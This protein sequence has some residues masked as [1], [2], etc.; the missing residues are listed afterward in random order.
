MFS[1]SKKLKGFKGDTF[2]IHDYSSKEDEKNMG[3]NL[4][5]FEIVQ[6]LSTKN[7]TDYTCKV[8]SLLN[9][10][11][12]VMKKISMK[13]LDEKTKNKLFIIVQKLTELNNPHII[14]YY[15]SFQD[16]DNNL[17]LIMEYMNNSDLFN[18]IKVHGELKDSIEKINE[19]QI[20]NLL[21]QG[22]SALEYFHKRDDLLSLGV[23]LEKIFMNNEENLKIGV[24]KWPYEKGFNFDKND[25]IYK[26][27]KYF[28]A[29]CFY[30]HE[31]VYE[32]N[33][34]ID[35]SYKNEN[36]SDFSS[37]LIHLIDN[38]INNNKNLQDIGYLFKEFKN[39]YNHKFNNNNIDSVLRC[40][41]ELPEI[42]AKYNNE[43]NI[44]KYKNDKEK[45]YINNLFANSVNSL[46][47]KGEEEL[48][49]IK[50]E[51][52]QL[53]VYEKSNNNNKNN[54][55]PIYVTAFLLQKMHL[56]ENDKDLQNKRGR[57]KTNSLLNGE[58]E[59]QTNELQMIHNF[60]S[61][62]NEN[63]NSPISDLFF[64]F[65]EI[66]KTCKKCNISKYSFADFCFISFDVSDMLNNDD[67]LDLME[68]FKNKG[69]SACDECFNNEC[70]IKETYFLKNHLI[71]TFN[72]GGKI[73]NCNIKS[74]DN[75]KELDLSHFIDIKSKS[76]KKFELIGFIKCDLCD[77]D[78]NKNN[79]D[80]YYNYS[81]KKKEEIKLF[82]DILIIMLFY[83]KKN[84]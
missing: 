7:I 68:L 83:A 17:Y 23:K 3:K 26:F 10:K 50:E 58:I 57:T 15:K 45:Y 67:T 65:K 24:F 16:N 34:I 51:I 19:S 18:F 30:A 62:F 12:Y 43:E 31:R 63:Y 5:D 29:L 80:L 2:F 21:Y 48:I 27:G 74:E 14:K 4:S 13:D 76:P 64:G 81:F 20:W 49:K 75:A 6:Y 42:K 55:D 66:T 71:I 8:R 82:K 77:N 59:D 69:E 73:K 53:I 25:D 44:K 60:N 39:D 79:D 52:R 54:I 1:Q 11:I 38:L 40:L 9:N 72:R 56:E 35:V 46:E 84:E 32:C 41:Y 22:F 28:H 70:E 36:N 61:Y 47:G 33:S 78:G 37:E